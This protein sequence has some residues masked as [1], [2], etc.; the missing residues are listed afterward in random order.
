M[1]IELNVADWDAEEYDACCT[2]T[3][4][5]LKINGIKIPLC[6]NCVEELEDKRDKDKIYLDFA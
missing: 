2:T 5:E 3:V 6:L 1:S 4:A